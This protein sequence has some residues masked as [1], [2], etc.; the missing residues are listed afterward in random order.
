MT[1]AEL[2][3]KLQTHR[4]DLKVYVWNEKEEQVEVTAVW[5]KSS[6]DLWP[7]VF[8]TVDPFFVVVID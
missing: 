4:A 2:I 6:R 3:Q 7:P 1:V 8:A 5:H